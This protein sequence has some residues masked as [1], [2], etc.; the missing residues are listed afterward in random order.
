[1]VKT[2]KTTTHSLGSYLQHKI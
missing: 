1:M 2:T